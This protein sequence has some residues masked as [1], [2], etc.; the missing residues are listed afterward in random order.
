[1]SVETEATIDKTY[2][3]IIQTNAQIEIFANKHPRHSGTWREGSRYFLSN[4]DYPNALRCYQHMIVEQFKIQ[5]YGIPQPLDY[6]IDQMLCILEEIDLISQVLLKDCIIPN[7]HIL[8]TL[9]VMDMM[10]DIDLNCNRSVDWLIMGLIMW[11]KNQ[12]ETSI[13]CFMR[14]IFTDRYSMQYIAS[15]LQII[16]NSDNLVLFQEKCGANYLINRLL[17]PLDISIKYINKFNY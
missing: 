3:L 17:H 16:K 1:M 11:Q 2:D 10:L 4:E 5:K 9:D 12:F 14:I 8:T 7:K 6:M 15:I 13:N